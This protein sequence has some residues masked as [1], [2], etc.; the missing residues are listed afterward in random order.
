MIWREFWYDGDTDILKKHLTQETFNPCRF[1]TYVGAVKSELGDPKNRNV[2]KCN[3]PS[4]EIEALRK[5]V[6]L[7]KEKHIVIKPCDKGAGII[8]LDFKEY[9]NACEKHLNQ[10]Y[11]NDDEQTNN[12]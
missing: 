6:Q 4:D 10:A 7:K 9:I 3:L 1:E 5:L 12:Y 11:K 8:I 2:S